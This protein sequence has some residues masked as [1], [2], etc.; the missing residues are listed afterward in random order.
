MNLA[1]VFAQR[2]LES[3]ITEVRCD[4]KPHPGGKV[5]HNRIAGDIEFWILNVGVLTFC[6]EMVHTILIMS[7]ILVT[8]IQK[9]KKSLFL[10][11][12]SWRW[13]RKGVDTQFQCWCGYSKLIKHPSFIIFPFFDYLWSVWWSFGSLV[14]SYATV[15]STLKWPICM[16]ALC[17]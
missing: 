5:S 2:C 6:W 7:D 13:R 12:C 3:G 4:L 10:Y 17:I 9:V 14:S 8:H 1:R 11:F 16:F 15:D